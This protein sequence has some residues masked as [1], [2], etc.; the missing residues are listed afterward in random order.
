[1][2]TRPPQLRM[3][4]ATALLACAIGTAR[5]TSAQ[6]DYEI[7]TLNGEVAGLIGAAKFGKALPLARRAVELTKQRFGEDDP[8]YA[9]AL[10]NRAS[11]LEHTNR[12]SEA[13]PLYRHRSRSWR[14]ATGPTMRTLGR[15]S[16]T[17]A[18]CCT[19]PAGLPSPRP[20][21]AARSPLP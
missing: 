11:L 6:S 17:W 12:L 10:N 1:M 16:A 4:L 18:V 14:S 20:C 3:V 9:V 5:P 7:A 19:P 8:S 21:C 13:E 15:Q 2:R